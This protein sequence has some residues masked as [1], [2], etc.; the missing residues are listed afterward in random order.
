[1]THVF[2]ALV[3]LVSLQ[4]THNTASIALNRKAPKGTV[5]IADNLWCD[6]TEITNLDWRE[7]T[8]W[9][10]QVYGQESAEYFA[11][12]PD[13]NGWRSIGS[14]SEPFVENYHKHPAY[15]DFPVVNITQEQAMAYA[16]W[17]TDRYLEQL[18]VKAKVLD[19]T[20]NYN[21]DEVFSLARTQQN[22]WMHNGQPLVLSQYPVFRLPTSEEF[23][24]LVAFNERSLQPLVEKCAK[25]KSCSECL[26]SYPAQNLKSERAHHPEFLHTFQ[27]STTHPCLTSRNNHLVYIKGNAAEWVAENN[28]IGGGH[29]GDDLQ[30]VD[31]AVVQVF[32]KTSG[33]EVGFRTV[34]EWRT[35]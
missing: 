19:N 34:L 1:M 27:L 18:L 35:K 13:S 24:Q 30:E 28:R 10:A 2:T 29:F 23:R 26:E 8:N 22:G 25:K 9:V 11:A 21:A 17:R 3:V 5:E 6:A 31:Q 4:I 33:P 20:P 7:Y 14:F 12:L 16:A 15:N 32:D